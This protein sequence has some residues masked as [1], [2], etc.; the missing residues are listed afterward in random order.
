MQS[1]MSTFLA[2]PQFPSDFSGYE[3]ALGDWEETRRKWGAVPGDRFNA[4]TKKALLMDEAPATVKT[5]LP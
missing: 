3:T 1:L 2:T 5:L 4:A